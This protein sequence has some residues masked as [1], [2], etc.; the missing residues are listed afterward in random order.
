MGDFKFR[1]FCLSKTIGHGKY[2]CNFKYNYPHAVFDIFFGMD[3]FIKLLHTFMARRCVG[4]YNRSARYQAKTPTSGTDD[5]GKN[6]S[7]IEIGSPEPIH[8]ILRPLN[9][10]ANNN[11]QSNA[12]EPFG[13]VHIPGFIKY[14]IPFQ[15]LIN[16]Y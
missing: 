9:V 1:I 4:I 2:K 5:E 11:V 10:F 3:L 7:L 6:N 8:S 12:I 14:Y 16:R 15:V 13:Y